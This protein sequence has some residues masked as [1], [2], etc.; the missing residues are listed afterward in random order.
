ME[1]DKSQVE[2]EED[3]DLSSSESSS[4]DL[5]ILSQALNKLESAAGEERGRFL[6]FTIPNVSHLFSTFLSALISTWVLLAFSKPEDSISDLSSIHT[7]LL[8]EL[9]LPPAFSKPAESLTFSDD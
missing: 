8:R 2:E 6:V 1:E 3:E 5:S 9:E 4:E 7:F